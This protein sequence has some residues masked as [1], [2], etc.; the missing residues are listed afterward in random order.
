[1]PPIRMRERVHSHFARCRSGFGSGCEWGV[2]EL[3]K[4]PR[5][6]LDLLT[7]DPKHTRIYR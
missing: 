6:P 5:D 4:L 3:S 2:A 1:V 7:G